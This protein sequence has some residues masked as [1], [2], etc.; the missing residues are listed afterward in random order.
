MN[1]VDNSN[2]MI[3]TLEDDNDTAPS[4]ENR[5]NQFEDLLSAIR[6]R[7]RRSE[8]ILAAHREQATNQSA[9][10]TSESHEASFRQPENYLDN[11]LND[12]NNNDLVESDFRLPENDE[13]EYRLPDIGSDE[14]ERE[15]SLDDI[16]PPPTPESDPDNAPDDAMLL[17]ENHEHED[18]GE[19]G[20]TKL[21]RRYEEER[22]QSPIQPKP[23]PI[24]P[25]FSEKLPED[26]SSNEIGYHAYLNYRENEHNQRINQRAIAENDVGVL[27]E[28]DWIAAQSALQTDRATPTQTLHLRAANSAEPEYRLD[29]LADE[30]NSP[31]YPPMTV[32][33]YDL[34]DL[35]STRKI[36]I[37]SEQELLVQLQHKLR[38]HLS[39]A[40]AGLMHHIL[41]KKL[42]TLSY[43]LQIMLNEETPRVVEDVLAH[44]MENILREIKEKY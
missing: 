31:D 15:Y 17:T 26:N 1:E 34:P 19:T 44:N 20:L 13:H 14:P 28:E 37:I 42:A 22:E 8:E 18:N 39:H 24:L 40:V 29:E 2:S 4:Y 41:Q 16:D 32:H 11:H 21:F 33:V 38:P 43:D 9:S 12:L 3:F 25:V 36:K 10:S 5:H 23:E 7:Y 27:I 35:P 6:K 30:L